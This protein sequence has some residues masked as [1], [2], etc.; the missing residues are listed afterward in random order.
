MLC[1]TDHIVVTDRWHT[2]ACDWLYIGLRG[3]RGSVYALT[4]VDLCTRYFIAISTIDKSGKS[5]VRALRVIFTFNRYPSVLVSDN[6]SM[7]C[8]PEFV[9]WLK[10]KNIDKTFTAVY[11]PRANGIDKRSNQTL[12]DMVKSC[13]FARQWDDE[14]WDLFYYYNLS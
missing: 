8:S 6:E 2:L 3:S 13:S 9:E 10:V 4:V 7:F 12:M 5:L 11:N 1:R 14:I